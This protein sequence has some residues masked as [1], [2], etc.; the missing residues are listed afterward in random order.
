MATIATKPVRQRARH[1]SGVV[2]EIRALH[3]AGGDV[4][5]KGRKTERLGGTAAEHAR[6]DQQHDEDNR[7][8]GDPPTPDLVRARCST[9]PGPSRSIAGAHVLRLTTHTAYRRRHGR[10][11]GSRGDFVARTPAPNCRDPSGAA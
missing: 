6:A 7:D 1:D 10:K 4:L 2:V 3:M 9:W 8:E 5:L 11:V